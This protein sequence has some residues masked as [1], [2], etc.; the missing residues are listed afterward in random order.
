MA[1][2]DRLGCSVHSAD[3]AVR[4]AGRVTRS[5]FETSIPVPGTQ[6]LTT[7]YGRLPIDEL[8]KIE[9]V[10]EK[11]LQDRPDWSEG[12]VR[13]GMMYLS[14]YEQTT[15]GVGRSGRERIRRRALMVANPLWVHGV[16]HSGTKSEAE[17]T[18]IIE[19]DPVWLFLI[20]AARSFLEARRCCPVRSLPHVWLGALDYLVETGE[21]TSMHIA[22]GTPAER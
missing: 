12:H 17:I 10:L 13:L 22:S 2:P 11:I 8:E 21:P 20:P 18:E 6:W 5:P 3:L 15:S 7:D 9:V 16:I 1:G 19:E 4:I 14:H